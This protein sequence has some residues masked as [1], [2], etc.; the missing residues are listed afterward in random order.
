MAFRFSLDALL[1]LQ[2]SYERKERRLLEEIAGRMAAIRQRLEEI[3]QMRQSASRQRGESLINGVT[4]AEMHFA[5]ACDEVVEEQHR[6]LSQSLVEIQI[7]HR[8]QKD[9]YLLARQK[10]EIL[11]SL[12][13]R[14]EAEY[15][16]ELARREQQS[17]DDLFLM[18]SIGNK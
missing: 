5:A 16:R 7:E 4:G 3:E 17:M 10:R 2:V 1:R 9:V 8:Q 11:D 12:R 15:R 13:D 18:R 6:Q 14:Q